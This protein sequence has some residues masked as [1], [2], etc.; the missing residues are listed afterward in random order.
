M[1][2]IFRVNPQYYVSERQIGNRTPEGVE[3][4]GE[5]W[6][7]AGPWQAYMIQRLVYRSTAVQ[8]IQQRLNAEYG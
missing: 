3:S 4:N 5:L 7:R 6:L 1:K 8:R 2:I